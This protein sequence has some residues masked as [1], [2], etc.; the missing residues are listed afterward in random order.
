MAKKPYSKLNK[1]EIT[2]DILEAKIM[3]E[4]LKSLRGIPLV[5]SK[6]LWKMLSQARQLRDSAFDKIV[7]GNDELVK[8]YID[9]CNF[10]IKTYDSMPA[11]TLTPNQKSNLDEALEIL[12]GEKYKQARE[13]D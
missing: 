3:E 10:I 12:F 11:G 8:P 7:G 13:E 6:D 2:P 9:I 1:S 4:H 5:K